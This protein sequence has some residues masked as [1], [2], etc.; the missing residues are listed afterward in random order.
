MIAEEIKMK[1]DLS[2]IT[3]MY[4]EEKFIQDNIKKI[5][6]TLKQSN[7]KWEYILINDGSSDNSY[8]LANNILKDYENCHII[9]YKQNKGRGFALRK[10][11]ENANGEY[12]VTTESDLSWGQDII[13]KIYNALISSGNDC[14][15]VSTYLTDNSYKNVPFYRRI[16]SSVG[17]HVIKLCMGG[18]LT[19]FSGMTRG[20]KA[21]AIKKIYLEEDSKLIHLEIVSKLNMLGYKISEIPGNIRWDSDRVNQG[22]KKHMG[23]IKHVIPHILHSADE[24]A[25]RMIFSISIIAF[26]IGFFL[27]VFGTLNKIFL[28]TATPKPYLVVYGFIIITLSIVSVLISILSLQIKSLKRSLIHLQKQINDKIH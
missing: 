16:L 4:N 28:I 14:I 9:S 24:G 5:I 19:M 3:P 25:F 8:Y 27:S 15:I 17:N 21:D 13:L 22:F 20:Y 18:N 1:Y 26:F 12:I 11:F 6:N 2:L 23:I 10:G 7:L